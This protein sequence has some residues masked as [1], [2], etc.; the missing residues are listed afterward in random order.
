MRIDKSDITVIT[1]GISL[2]VSGLVIRYIINRRRFNRKGEGGLQ[3]FKSYERATVITF[4]KK[5]IMLLSM[6]MLLVGVVFLIAV[7]FF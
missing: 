1:I 2:L 7:I 6:I 5:I 3:H 4:I